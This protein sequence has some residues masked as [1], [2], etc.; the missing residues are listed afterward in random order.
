MNHFLVTAAA[1]CRMIRLKNA[2]K[3][4][5]TPS[6]PVIYWNIMFA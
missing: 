4:V 6:F 5:N 2:G 1:C 3:P